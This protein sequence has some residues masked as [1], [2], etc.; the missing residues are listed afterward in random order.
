MGGRGLEGE[1]AAREG[2]K[3]EAGEGERELCDSSQWEAIMLTGKGQLSAKSRPL[4]WSALCRECCVSNGTGRVAC[5]A[6]RE[7]MQHAVW[8]EIV[9][10]D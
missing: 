6:A 4:L 2:E 7:R 9:A 5:K 10:G 3:E 1:G 8:C